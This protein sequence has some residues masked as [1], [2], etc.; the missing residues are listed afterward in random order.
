MIILVFWVIGS[1]FLLGIF[2][3]YGFSSLRSGGHEK[4]KEVFIN[5]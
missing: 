4:K 1:C 5:E 2:G 3:L